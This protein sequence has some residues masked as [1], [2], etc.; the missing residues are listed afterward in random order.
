MKR[1]NSKHSIDLAGQKLIDVRQHLQDERDYSESI[2]ETIRKPLLVLDKDLRVVSAGRAFYDTFK[3]KEK[4]TEGKLIYKLGNGQWNIPALKVLLS[5][6]LSKKSVFQDY[7]IDHEF[8]TI[9]KKHMILNGREIKRGNGKSRLILLAIEDVTE[10]RKAMETIK[11]SNQELTAANQELSALEQELRSS[12]QQLRAHEQQQTAL[13][14]QLKSSNQQLIAAEQHLKDERDYSESII[15]T[16]RKPLLVLDKDLRVVSAGRAFYDTFKVKEKETEGKLIYKLGNGQWNIPALKVLLSNVLSKK[17]VFQDYEIDHEFRTIG[18]KH[19]ILNGREL[20]RGDGKNRLI[21]LAI[22]DVTEKRKAIET[23]KASNQELTAANQELSALEQELR[24]SNRQLTAHEKQQKG[25]RGYAESIIDTI[26]EPILVLDRDLRVVSASRSFYNTFKVKEKETEKKLVYELGNGQWNIPALK[27]LLTN[28]LPKKSV[29]QSYEIE[30]EFT[31]IGKKN[32]ILNARE[33]KREGSE[34]RL[35]LLAIEDV[36]EKRKA[37]EIIK[38]SNQQL[39]GAN[40]RLTAIEQQLKDERDYAESIIG[41]IRG[42]LLV[43]DKDLRVVSASRS[44]YEKFKVKEKETEGKLVYK[45]GNGQWNIPALKTLLT[46]ILPKKSIFQDYAI[47]D[48]TETRKAMEIIKAA[49]QQIKYERDYAESIIGTIREPLLILDKDLRVVSASRSFY[50]KFKV[51]EKETEGKLV[52]ELGNGQWDIPALKI[53]L[54]NILPNK[55]IFQGYEIEHEFKTIGKKNMILNARELK[56][57]DGES[58]LILLAIEDVTEKRKAEEIIKA[59]NQKL[60]TANR[61]L[62]AAEQQI[63]YERDYSESIIGTMREPLLVLDKDLRVV[64]ANR[65][66]YGTFKV[67]EKETEGNLVYELGNGQWNIPALKTLLT[68]ILPK[69]NIFQGYEIEH[70]FKTIGKKNMILNARELKRGGS[71]NRLILLAIEDVTEKRKAGEIIKAANQ[72]LTNT[73]QELTAIELELRASN[74]QLTEIEEQLKDERDYAESI[75]GTIR[76]PLLVLDK[77]LRVVS[78]SRSF[79]DTFKVKAKETEGNLVYKLG[80]EQ[81]NIPALRILLTNILPEKSV[82]Q[83]YEVEHEFKTIGKKNMILNAKE[84]KSENHKN[85][86]ILL[87]IEDVTEKRKAE[88]KVKAAEV[89]KAANEQL[90]AANKQL[91]STEQ[92]LR[93]FNEQLKAGAQK[94]QESELKY[95]TLF[96]TSVDGILIAEIETRKLVYANPSICKMLGYT[97]EELENMSITDIYPKDNNDNLKNNI[98][99]FGSQK[100]GVALEADIP[101]LKKNTEIVYVDINVTVASIDGKECNVGFFRDVVIRKK[102]QDDL[103]KSDNKYQYLIENLNEG[104]WVIDRDNL[105]TFTNER[106]AKMLGYEAIE[107]IGKSFFSF[108]DAVGIKIAKEN[109]ERQKN[110]IKEQHDFEFQK[111]DGKKMFAVLETAPILD[112]GGK[113]NGSIAGVI[114]ITDRKKLEEQL[115]Q[116]QKMESVGILAGGIAHDF[117]NLLTAIKGY[118]EL[119]KESTAKD[120]PIYDDL[121]EICLAADRAADLTRQ[122]LLFSRK[123]PLNP[124]NLNL[125][126]IIDNMSKMLNRIIGEDISIKTDLQL[127]LWNTNS[128]ETK[129]EQIIMNLTINGRDAMNKGGVLTIKTENVIVS[130]EYSMNI[131]E[132]YPG[133]FVKLSIQDNG[134][135]INKEVLQHIFEPYFT[136][137]GLGKGTGLGLSVVYGIVKQHNGWINVY[138][139]PDRGTMFTIYLPSSSSEKKGEIIKEKYNPDDLVGHGER[140]LVVEDEVAIRKYSSRV[141]L[142]NGYTVFLAGDVNEAL[143]IFEKEKNNIKMVLSDVVLPDGTGIDLVNRLL[144]E[145]PEFKVILCS[146]YLDDRSQQQLIHGKGHKFLHKPFQLNEL[147]V[148]VKET[149]AEGS[150]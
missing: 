149:L 68:N 114:D 77:D 120:N 65:A 50:D 37:E 40:Q 18:K 105:T 129:M 23:I 14:Q 27:T 69:K 53:L 71:E 94:L 58:R 76:E 128:D 46:N 102:A 12:N 127:N 139:E 20:K 119:A 88:E 44:F 144:L 83:D 74:R 97:K 109:M 118:S 111:K 138:S 29:F 80:N 42:L 132:S 67:K 24:S 112:D 13:E 75:I 137:K 15:G 17:S 70:E 63:K 62:T 142:N 143:T 49:E 86:L 123:Q 82:F 79:Y 72:K 134:M 21:L 36:T 131:A 73:N 64:S 113:Y 141:L 61:E 108:M 125:N 133:K 90:I 41:T 6:V 116:S 148:A 11:A 92:Q 48:I 104:V 8:K 19:M 39:L 100:E 22:E 135:G 150:K 93:T 54:T 2:I 99:K 1:K 52:Y 56:R 89:I 57:A 103:I 96:E 33:L 91:M 66:F 16:I 26:R 147:L 136:T 4:E 81:W 110:G 31:T 38:A 126:R 5:N 85:R 51:K 9:G 87:A 7:E 106:M 145:K 25:E 146:G 35:I 115:L 98:S 121:N 28:I 101:C 43:L 45:L 78:A 59:A 30:H 10:K 122:V 55:N 32:M 140:I 60:T 3:V 107:M 34:D 130:K 95:R 124:I 117:N 47:E 84:L